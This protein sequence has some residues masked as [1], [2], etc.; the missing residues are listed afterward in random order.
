MDCLWAARNGRR[1]AGSGQ[2]GDSSTI[3]PRDLRAAPARAGGSRLAPRRARCPRCT[4]PPR[5]T[6]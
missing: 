5:D 6:G 3:R 4:P 2:P 1:L